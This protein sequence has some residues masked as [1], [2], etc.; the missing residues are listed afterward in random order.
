MEVTKQ[1]PEDV[2]VKEFP[3]TAQPL[4]VPL[5][6]VKETIPLPEPPAVARAM[7]VPNIPLD[8]LTLKGDCAA[9]AKVTAVRLELTG[10]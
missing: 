3:E 4:A 9:F 10:S 8:V 6:T 2:E 5:E 7:V 1:V